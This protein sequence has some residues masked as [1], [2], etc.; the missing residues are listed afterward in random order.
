MFL[1]WAVTSLL[2]NMAS[3]YL[4]GA[5]RLVLKDIIMMAAG[6]LL[7]SESARQLF[8]KIGWYLS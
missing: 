1:I 2:H 4:S 5:G 8:E 6:L 7:A 3:P